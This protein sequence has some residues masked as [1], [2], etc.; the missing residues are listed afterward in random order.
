MNVAKVYDRP[1]VF[2]L[3]RPKLLVEPTQNH[4][5]PCNAA[6]I[7]FYL[8]KLQRGLLIYHSRKLKTGRESRLQKTL[9][10][11]KFMPCI[12][13]VIAHLCGCHHLLSL[14]LFSKDSAAHLKDRLESLL[15]FG[16]VLCKTCDGRLL[17]SVLD[18]LPSATKG[19]DL[20][21][22]YKLCFGR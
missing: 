9:I 12:R 18:L 19:Y 14:F 1:R 2:F 3:K 10:A 16:C 6:Q 15:S 7:D 13:Y 4:I 22:L 11:G 21:G 8:H 17:H 20:C 5:T